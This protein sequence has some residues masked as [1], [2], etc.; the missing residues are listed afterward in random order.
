MLTALGCAAA[1]L[2]AGNAN[3]H[4]VE[5]RAFYVDFLKAV[6]ANDKETIAG[7]IAF[8]V[9]DYD[10]YVRRGDRDDAVSIKDKAEFLK[11][12]DTFF[13]RSTR[14]HL[15][16]AKATA[17]QGGRYTA[18]WDEGETEFTFL[19]EYVEGTGYRVESF[20]TGARD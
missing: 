12:Y 5:F 18:S 8:P 17:L 4:D 19:F 7:L 11:N 14:L 20:T 6:Q 9:G 2:A 3:P 16:K 10:W 1:A 15:L 13:T